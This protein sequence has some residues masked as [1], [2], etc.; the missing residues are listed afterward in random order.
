MYIIHI[1]DKMTIISI[2]KDIYME[3]KNIKDVNIQLIK[4]IRF[5]D[6]RCLQYIYIYNG[7]FLN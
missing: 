3:G 6:N 2:R 5:D 7:A 4:L 1:H